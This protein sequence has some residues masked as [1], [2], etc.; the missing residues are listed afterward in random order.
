LI[1]QNL[2]QT[3]RFM[4]GGR[5]CLLIILTEYVKKQEW[6]SIISVL[7]LVNC[8]ILQRS[9][10]KWFHSSLHPG[11]VKLNEQKV[12]EWNETYRDHRSIFLPSGIS[13]PIVIYVPLFNKS[14]NYEMTAE[15]I[16]IDYHDWV[17]SCKLYYS[18]KNQWYMIIG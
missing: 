8:L 14:F 11:T 10:G 2:I 16:N 5:R 12:M 15:A 7:L 6:C 17:F 13:I 1:L 9:D 18:K 4:N 3:I